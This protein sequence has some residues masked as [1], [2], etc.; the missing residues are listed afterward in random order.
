MSENAETKPIPFT[1]KPAKEKPDRKYR[2]GSKY[3]DLLDAF[4]KGTDSLVEVS[5]E[6]KD[7]NYI[8]TQL[9]KRIKARKLTKRMNVSVTNNVCYLQKGEKTKKEK[10][11]T[12]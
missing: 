1:L 3:D 2:K 8:R 6:G 7:S 4:L 9:D 12:E 10:P 11:K 5:V